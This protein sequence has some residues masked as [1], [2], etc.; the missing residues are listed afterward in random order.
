MDE[1]IKRLSESL[2]VSEEQARKTVLITA[3]HLKHKLPDPVYAQLELALKLPEATED[4]IKEL[5]LFRFP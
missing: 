1:L 2:G 4:E 5:G 3:D